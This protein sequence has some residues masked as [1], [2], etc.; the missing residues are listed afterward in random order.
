MYKTFSTIFLAPANAAPRARCL[1][2]ESEC[3]RPKNTPS[4]NKIKFNCAE[5][6]VA[7]VRDIERQRG[8]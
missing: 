7:A 6:V 4:Y 2:A 5:F 8:K 1:L 3:A